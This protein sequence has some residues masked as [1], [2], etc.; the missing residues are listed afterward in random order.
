MCGR[1]Y[2]D[3]D[4]IREIARLVGEIDKTGT[5][6]GDILPSRQAAVITGLGHPLAAARMAWGFLKFDGKGLVINARAESALEKRSFRESVLHR[7]CVIPARGFYEWNKEKEKF[8]FERPDRDVLFMAGCFCPFDG[9]DRF[10]ILTTAANPSVSP[11]HSR[12]PL[13]LERD[14]LTAWVRDDTAAARLLEKAPVML[15]RKT[16]Y[17]QLRLF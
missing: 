7:R 4:T 17:E 2:A 10:V 15:T 13:I 8:T 3:D 16:E 9:Q 6:A 12:M 1:Y 11:V 5:E 14:E